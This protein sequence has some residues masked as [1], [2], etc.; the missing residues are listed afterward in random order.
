MKKNIN[1]QVSRIKQMMG[2]NEERVDLNDY[3]D[4]SSIIEDIKLVSAAE[5]GSRITSMKINTFI[6][7]PNSEVEGNKVKIEFILKWEKYNYWSM[8]KGRRVDEY[9]LKSIVEIKSDVELDEKLNKTLVALFSGHPTPRDLVGRLYTPYSSKFSKNTTD[10]DKIY[11]N[12]KK[13]REEL[14]R[15]LS[16]EVSQEAEPEMQD[17]PMVEPEVSSE[18][19]QEKPS[20]GNNMWSSTSSW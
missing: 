18:T 12:V 6:P 14:E 15:V 9:K 16:G 17:A 11:N 4:E 5:D 3:K 8:E 20:K 13:D 10:F 7:T 1:E 19:P 2:L